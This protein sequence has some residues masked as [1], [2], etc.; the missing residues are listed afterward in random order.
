MQYLENGVRKIVSCKPADG[1]PDD[2]YSVVV[3]GG[4]LPWV[5]RFRA[6]LQNCAPY[7]GAVRI[8][9]SQLERL[10]AIVSVPG[11]VSLEVE[12]SA[13]DRATRDRIGIHIEST[14]CRGGPWG[15]TPI[16]G[17]SVD[18]AR[19]YRVITGV[20]GAVVVTGQ[21]YGWA[22]R[23]VAAGATVSA[24]AGPA[25]AIGPIGVPPN[26]EVNG[27]ARGLMAPIST[28]TFVNTTGYILEVV[29]PGDVFDG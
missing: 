13:T 12:G 16:H 23:A 10:V 24:A 3:N 15:V 22:A 17:V 8:F 6:K 18:G 20:S 28:W 4:I 2:C 19:S 29:P 7:V 5:L 11:A 26:G 14:I 21:V 1:R 9:P 27:D 25:L